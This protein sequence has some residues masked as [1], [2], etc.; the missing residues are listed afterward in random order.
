MNRI[1]NPQWWDAAY[2]TAWEQL[3]LACIHGMFILTLA[4][5]P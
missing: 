4:S 5:R 2:D 3:V 1:T